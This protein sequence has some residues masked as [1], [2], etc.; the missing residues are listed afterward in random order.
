M[1][2]DWPPSI[3][4]EIVELVERLARR[5]SLGDL[6]WFL[7]PGEEA[8]KLETRGLA[9]YDI[10]F[11]ASPVHTDL[12]SGRV[13]L[14]IRVGARWAPAIT[15]EV[16][17]AAGFTLQRAWINSAYDDENLYPKLQ[18][19]YDRALVEAQVREAA[20]GADIIG[21]MLDELR[22]DQP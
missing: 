15:V 8:W 11:P 19:I 6:D 2:E 20:E 18:A 22:G 5:T 16:K 14:R 9:D 21:D 12:G 17:D 1:D 13:E 4:G 7:P 3:T 10:S